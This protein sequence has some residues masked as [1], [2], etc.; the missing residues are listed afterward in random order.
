MHQ[1]EQNVLTLLGKQAKC[2]LRRREIATYLNLRG[3]E[4]KQLTTSLNQMVRKGLLEERKGGYRLT[5][6]QHTLEGIFSRTEQG[7]GFLRL[8]DATQEDLFIPARHVNNAI[9]G[10]RLLVQRRYS[11]RDRRPYGQVVRIL[12]RAHTRL[13]GCYQ[14]QGKGAVVW[15]LEQKL[16]GPIRVGRLQDIR[17]GDLVEVEIERYAAGDSS[18]IGRVAEVLGSPDDPQVDIETVI[19][20]HDLPH[21]FSPEVLAEAACVAK[22]FPV[23]ELQRR[24][25]LRALPLM[26]IDGE[27]AKDFDDAVALRKEAGDNY[28]LWVCIADVAHYVAEGGELDQAARERGTSVYF[29]GYCLPML[30]ETLSNGVCSL[31]P[32]EDRL[33]MTAEMLFRPD[34]RC[35][36]ADF[37]P[38]VMCSQA[39]LTY[40]EVAAFLD[41]AADIAIAAEIADQLP[42]MAELA[43]S[44]GRMRYERGCLALD[45]PEVEIILDEKGFPVSVVKAERTIA[46]RLIEE[47]MLAANEAVASF[48]EQRNYPF[49]YR[50]HESPSIDKLQNFQQL[51]AECG[52]GLVLG[53]RLQHDLQQLL[54][55]IVERPEARLLNQQLLRSLQ[56]A[57][58]APE[59]KGHFGLASECYC[60]FTSPIRRYPDL[61]VHRAL[62]AAVRTARKQA[63]L[64][65]AALQELG[66]DC[67]DKERRAMA[68]ERDLLELRRCQ[69]MKERIGEQF[70]GTI[71]AVAEFGFFVE[72]DDLYVEG[73]VHVRSL[74][75]DYYSFDPTSHA[76][77]GE[78]R[79]TVFKVGMPVRIRIERVELW[80]RRLDFTLVERGL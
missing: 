43:E 68:A 47:F 27:T 1:L 38:A 11:T 39:R 51:L 5:P 12:E 72:L 9:D 67:S 70:T 55:E 28:R 6:G 35:I 50:V 41:G 40:S 54:A 61:L 53:K 2:S 37:Y 13:I 45:V 69:L 46:H 65:D 31:N 22:D 3:A 48:L 52:I 30:P 18:A 71:S 24:T 7:F 64:A 76:L 32:D 49:L 16:G 44:L 74:V 78:R 56:Q 66:R 34:G 23:E 33:V 19:R 29:P 80:R 60:H 62:K 42:I 73:L 77:V 17:P 57:R 25:D 15:P 4:R 8:S 36:E 21:N 10:D 14:L 58:Y 75:G 59:N 63:P 26:T 20:S 79:R